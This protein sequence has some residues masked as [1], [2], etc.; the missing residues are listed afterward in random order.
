MLWQIFCD[1]ASLNA[2]VL[3]WNWNVYR[4][5]TYSGAFPKVT[6][7][8]SFRLKFIRK[9]WSGVVFQRLDTR[10]NTHLSSSVSYLSRPIDVA[11]EFRMKDYLM[12]PKHKHHMGGHVLFYS[13]LQQKGP[14][15]RQ[16]AKRL[17]KEQCTNQLSQ[18]SEI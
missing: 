11:E 15:F 10:V 18:R 13:T 1:A 4:T 5:K 3:L 7:N 17:R 16:D 14:F 8:T 9:N 2:W 12:L 6:L